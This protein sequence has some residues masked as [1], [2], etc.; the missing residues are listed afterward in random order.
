MVGGS[1]M[2][3]V[4]YCRW[5]LMESC[6]W[7]LVPRRR[8]LWVTSRSSSGERRPEGTGPECRNRESYMC[9][10]KHIH[11]RT[12]IWGILY[13]LNIFVEMW[14][15]FTESQSYRQK[16]PSTD[17]RPRHASKQRRCSYLTTARSPWIS[18]TCSPWLP[19]LPILQHKS[20]GEK[21]NGKTPLK[22]TRMEWSSESEWNKVE[23]EKGDAGEDDEMKD[24]CQERKT[25]LVIFGNKE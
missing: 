2:V 23:K 5:G 22:A 11:V 7:Q 1:Q 9:T 13:K 8:F 24:P 14:K 12:Y 4:V 25:V 17:S 3:L 19:V 16:Y 15:C 6:K 18:H 20:E 10:H 21:E